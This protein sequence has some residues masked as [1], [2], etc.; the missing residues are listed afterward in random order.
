MYSFYDTTHIV[1]RTCDIGLFYHIFIY[2]ILINI[3]FELSPS[4]FFSDDP[5]LAVAT[6]GG[7]LLTGNR[8]KTNQDRACYKSNIAK[9]CSKQAW[10]EAFK[11]KLEQEMFDA[12]QEEDRLRREQEQ[13]EEHQHCDRKDHHGNHKGHYDHDNGCQE[14]PFILDLYHH[15]R[16]DDSRPPLPPPPSPPLLV[17]PS[18]Q[19]RP[20][21]HV[22][23]L[24]T[25]SHHQHN[26]P[27]DYSSLHCPIY[28]GTTQHPHVMSV[29]YHTYI[30]NDIGKDPTVTPTRTLV[31]NRSNSSNSSSV[32]E[33]LF[34]R[35][36]TLLEPPSSCRRCRCTRATL[37]Y[38]VCRASQRQLPI[39][40]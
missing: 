22:D 10:R 23:R 38:L 37:T 39:H 6:M 5:P 9:F 14:R 35:R 33:C 28:R 31:S 11:I 15:K 7:R 19:Q 13:E 8:P 21:Q 26:N 40:F 16:K 29:T 25:T 1:R 30:H 36:S 4:S 17:L 24:A 18:Q 32:G 3:N 20:L 34:D 2:F 27:A 12:Q